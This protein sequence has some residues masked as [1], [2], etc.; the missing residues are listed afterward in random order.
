MAAS[1]SAATYWTTEAATANEM[2]IPPAISTTSSPTAKIRFTELVLRRLK[3]LATVRNCAVVRDNPAH[4]TKR[5]IISQVS[6]G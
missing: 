1:A 2:S 3:R 6:V 4:M 5:T